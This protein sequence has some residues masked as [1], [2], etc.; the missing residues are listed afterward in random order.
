MDH[1]EAKQEYARALRMGQKEYK[2]LSQ[3]GLPTAPAVLEELLL[4]K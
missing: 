2:E 4:K 1:L 3:K